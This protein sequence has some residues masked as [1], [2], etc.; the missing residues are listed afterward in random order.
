VRLR[1]KQAMGGGAGTLST[2]Y[3]R[4]G[5][6]ILCRIPTIR[7]LVNSA[8]IQFSNIVKNFA[9]VFLPLSL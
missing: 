8:K 1:C 6:K 9:L 5:Y 2:Y 4:K 3:P 7:I